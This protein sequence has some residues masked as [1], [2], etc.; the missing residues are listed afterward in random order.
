MIFITFYR[1]DEP[2]LPSLPLTQIINTTR[3]ILSTLINNVKLKEEINSLRESVS[4]DNKEKSPSRKRRRLDSKISQR[5][6]DVDQLISDLC[7]DGEL[8]IASDLLIDHID[9]SINEF[10]AMG[11][12]D[13]VQFEIQLRTIPKQQIKSWKVVNNLSLDIPPKVLGFLVKH[14]YVNILQ[15]YQIIKTNPSFNQF[16]QIL[17][18]SSYNDLIWS[19]IEAI[20]DTQHATILYSFIILHNSDL[21][22]FN[23]DTI[24]I[25]VLSVM[26]GCYEDMMCAMLRD[27]DDVLTQFQNLLATNSEENFQNSVSQFISFSH[28]I[29]S[30]TIIPTMNKMIGLCKVNS[31]NFLIIWFAALRPESEQCKLDQYLMFLSELIK[32]AISNEDRLA[33]SYN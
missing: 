27:D 8:D 10:R 23:R 9:Q 32:D 1:M 33:F 20:E 13:M 29:S 31:R 6:V 2:P 12:V 25:R 28:K 22:V 5:S 21:T 4:G 18:K 3:N 11:D 17:A 26:K 7:I 19:F 30:D 15:F 24:S 16:L 14:S